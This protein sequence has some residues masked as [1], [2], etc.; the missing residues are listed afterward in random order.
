VLGKISR[1]SL[2][3]VVFPLEEQ[4]LIPTTTA[5]LSAMAEG[6]DSRSTRPEGVVAN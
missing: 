6:P 3:R 1:R 5:F 2:A 4:P